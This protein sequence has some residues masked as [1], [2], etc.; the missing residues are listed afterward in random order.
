MVKITRRRFLLAKLESSYGVDPSPSPSA[1]ALQVQNIQIKEFFPPNERPQLPGL[2]PR[3]SLSGMRYAEVT[4]TAELFNVGSLGTAPRL[5]AL[6]KACDFAETISAGSSVIYT[7]GSSIQNTVTLYV[8]MDG[9]RHIVTACNGDVKFKG[10]AGKQMLLDFNFKGTWAT[11]TDQT[12]P[13]PTYES[14]VDKPPAILSASLLYNSIS[15]L[16]VK[17]VEIDLG[18]I[19]AMREDVNQAYGIKGFFISGK[20]PIIKIDPEA[21]TIANVDWRTDLLTTP[22]AFS[23]NIGTV[24]TN[25][26]AISV[27]KFNVKDIQYKDDQGVIK[28]EVTGELTDSVANANDALSL[29]FK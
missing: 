29:T 8:Y 6:F 18:N 27:P 11:P 19:I 10:V 4:F 21:D 12:N 1:D 23:M 22:R 20:K 16:V 13:S 17:T 26:I 3:P 25:M 15:T 2:T 14:N 28:T 24:S 5:G 9:I 7:L